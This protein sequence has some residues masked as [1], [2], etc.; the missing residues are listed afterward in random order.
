VGEGL[1]VWD[2]MGWLRTGWY[3]EETEGKGNE[4]MARQGKGR[5]EEDGKNGMDWDWAFSLKRCLGHERGSFVGISLG[6]VFFFLFFLS[7]GGICVGFSYSVFSSS[8]VRFS[9]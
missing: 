4:R 6:S 1:G 8:H 3:K 5:E 9:W 7:C 2:G